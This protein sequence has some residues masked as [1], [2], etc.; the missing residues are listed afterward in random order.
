MK[1]MP[2]LNYRRMFAFLLV[3]G[4]VLLTSSG[5][6][7]NS[8]TGG[9]GDMPL[10]ARLEP[11]FII[12]DGEWAAIIFYRP[13]DCIPEG[14]NLLS[15]IDYDAYNCFPPTT[16]GIAIWSGEPWM[17]PPIQLQLHENGL[18]PVWFVQW[19]ELQ[20]AIADDKLTMP[21]LEEFSLLLVGAADFYTETLHP[22][23]AH[24]VPMINIIAKGCLENGQSFSVHATSVWDLM[25]VKIT[26]GNPN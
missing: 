6:F 14:F 20:A 11:G 7:A 1:T 13:T 12:N 15:V 9:G 19:S 23:D 5:A 4:V 24:N 26:F 25:N 8:K 3:A 16:D 10:Y 17:S 2:N 22:T 21:E 18:V